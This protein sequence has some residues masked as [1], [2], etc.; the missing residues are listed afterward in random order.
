MPWKMR[1]ED[2]P[3]RV[4]NGKQTGVVGKIE[5]PN[6]IAVVSPLLLLYCGVVS[7]KASI[8]LVV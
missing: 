7:I 8:L 4:V 2:I 3:D 6:A 1:V 5:L